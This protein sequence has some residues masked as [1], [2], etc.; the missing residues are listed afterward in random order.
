MN[1]KLLI[2]G[3]ILMIG[4]CGVYGMDITSSGVYV[5]GSDINENEDVN[6]KADNVAIIGDNKQIGIVFI[7]KSDLKNITIID[8]TIKELSIYNYDNNRIN[9]NNVAISGG[10]YGIYIDR[11][12]NN[13]ISGNISKVYGGQYGIR[14]YKGNNNIIEGVNGE[15][16]GKN[17]GI[18]ISNSKDNKISGNISK[19]YGGRYGIR[20]YNGK[21]NKI[22]G[23]D[24]IPSSGGEGTRN[25]IYHC[26]IYGNTYS[27]HSNSPL[28]TYYNYIDNKIYYTKGDLVYSKSEVEYYL[29]ET[30]Y[31][32]GETDL[33]KVIIPKE[34]AE[35][36]YIN[37]SELKEF[38]NYM[39]NQYRG[40]TGNDT[41]CD[42]IIDD[43]WYS[44]IDK[45]PLIGKPHKFIDLSLKDITIDDT[46]IKDGTYYLI[47]LNK[48]YKIN[49]I[50]GHSGASVSDA[51]VELTA[52]TTLVGTESVSFNENEDE[53]TLTLYWTPTDYGPYTL[54]GVVDYNNSV[55]ETN[56]DNNTY[57][58]T[59]K[60]ID[61]SIDFNY[62]PKNPKVNQAVDFTPIIKIN[63]T[64]SSDLGEINLTWDFGD[65]SS[66]LLD[67]Y[68]NHATHKYS[69]VNDYGY[70]V[71]LTANS[72]LGWS[73][74]V[75][76]LIIISEKNYHPIAKFTFS[77]DGT[78]VY[79]DASES[80]DIDG[81]IVKYIWDF[82]DGTPS[83]SINGTYDSPPS[84]TINHTYSEKG[85]VYTVKLIVVD[86]NEYTGDTI[87][88]VDILGENKSVPLPPYVN[89]L[90][91]IIT[92]ISITYIMRGFK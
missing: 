68:P 25:L 42:G 40:L 11:S 15:I 45:Y 10:K 20:I 82:G 57:E 35:R 22:S 5:V 48:T 6:I 78:T 36:Y 52:N 34:D 7:K 26:K 37:I 33:F 88:F 75:S 84:P 32:D 56:E 67:K 86:D 71:F 51:G 62:T 17:Y 1:P 64:D 4:I 47:G 2:L 61:I 89:I 85:R 83:V 73:D 49:L 87:R 31:L 19:V 3:L 90:L 81:K 44:S 55:D 69:E 41:N 38:N 79:F 76:H 50:I 8:L 58:I 23:A 29:N 24:Y 12:N 54:K 72:E 92:M 80:Y 13:K 59:V 30:A 77:T 63:G 9:L 27:V 16:Y 18:Q 28:T 60:V 74:S 39:G 43:K 14:I 91:V 53:K 65:G 70:L 21:N 46:L 66:E